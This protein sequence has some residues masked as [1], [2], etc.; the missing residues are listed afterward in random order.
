MDNRAMS[1]RNISRRTFLA[2]AGVVLASLTVPLASGPAAAFA[3][4]LAVASA[5]GAALDAAEAGAPVVILHTNDVHCT[6]SNAKTKLGYAALINYAKTQREKYGEGS[7]KLVD[8]GDNVQG[9]F[10]GSFTKGETPAQV[11]AACGYDLL[12]PGNHEFDYGQ[13]Q[14][15][16]LRQTE[17][18]PYVCCNYLDAGGT[19]IFDAYRVLEY[20]TP[21]GTVR[22]AFVGVT[23]PSTLTSSSPASFKDKDG[24]VIYSFCGDSTGQLLYDTVQAAVDEARDAGKA[25]YVVLLS[26][27]GESGATD[28]WRSDTV[29]ANTTGIDVVVDGHSHEMYVQTVKNQAGED[30]VI[31]QTGTQFQSF[32]R[33]EINPVD[34]TATASLD[35]TGIDGVSAELI[36]QWDGEDATI[37]EL[38]A[39]LEAELE[40]KKQSP[41]GTSEALLRFATDDGAVC[42]IR[43]QETNLGDFCCDAVFYFASNSGSPCDLAV[44]NGGGIRA[45]IA[46]G[47]VTYGDLAAVHPFMNPVW[48]L[49]V[50]GQH[51]LDMLEVGVMNQPDSSGAFLQVSEGASYTVR[52][53]IPTPVVL[54][55]DGSA[56]KGFSGERRVKHARIDGKDID[57]AAEYTIAG[58][59]F[60][61]L[62]GG[63]CMPVPANAADAAFLG[64]DLDVL[65]EYIQVNLK[66]VIGEAY[67]DEAGQGRIVITDH[68]TEPDPAPTPGGGGQASG[69]GSGD[70]SNG[71]SGANGGS[72]GNGGNQTSG[73]AKTSAKASAS[74]G[75]STGAVAGAAAAVAGTAAISAILASAKVLAGKNDELA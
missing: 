51:I 3:D 47:T 27:L 50:S 36:E 20:S 40:Q 70:G 17:G 24:N 14:F 63:S 43:E 61:L 56:L 12:T 73:A 23:T 74:T 75:D 7:V 42:V 6:L 72:G 48:L 68:E 39:K 49:K 45:N 34:G 4:G 16:A 22:V 9:G 46:E 55:D 38:V 60:I 71:A 30:V 26:H 32:G 18:V 11:I 19:R 35:A 41:I 1:D 66:G 57:P 65:S 15:F 2:G 37:A 69:G 58:A 44:V 8:A 62:Q 54:E 25:D 21:A 53:D 31:A 59:A 33:I 10:E 13:E 67:A 28:R 52:T 64:V 29:V 5:D